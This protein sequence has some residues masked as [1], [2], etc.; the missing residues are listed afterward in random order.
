MNAIEELTDKEE[1]PS[2]LDVYVA[3]ISKDVRPKAFEITQMLRKNGFKTDVD[4]NG[5]KFK[6]LMNYA[7]KIKVEKLVIIGAND[8]AE[9]KVTVK[10]MISG[11]QNLVDIDKLVDY[12]K[13]E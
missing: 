2:H 13:E 12:L 3:P 9:G 11:E 7:D 5:K 8:L 6:K 4:L 1:L 10:N